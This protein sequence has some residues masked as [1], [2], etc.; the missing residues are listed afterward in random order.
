V[1]RLAV[2]L[3]G[4]APGI[5][6]ALK[7]NV[8]VYDD[9]ARYVKRLVIEALAS[10]AVKEHDVHDLVH[11]NEIK[12][13]LGKLVKELRTERNSVTVG[14]RRID[15]LGHR[16]RNVHQKQAEKSMVAED[17]HTRK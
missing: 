2:F 5:H 10:R 3:Q 9:I 1:H 17:A 16:I 11:H 7:Q 15:V 4:D 14:A 6:I 12:L 13:T 8:G